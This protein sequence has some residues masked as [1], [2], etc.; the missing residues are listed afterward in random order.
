ML[1]KGEFSELIEDE[2]GWYIYKAL[3]VLNKPI[4]RIYLQRIYFAKRPPQIPESL[5]FPNEEEVQTRINLIQTALQQG[6]DFTDVAQ[7]YS[8]D[9]EA[10]FSGGGVSQLQAFGMSKTNLGWL[11]KSAIFAEFPCLQ[12]N[13]E[14]WQVNRPIGPINSCI[15]THFFLAEDMKTAALEVLHQN[16]MLMNRVEAE[17]RRKLNQEERMELFLAA[18]KESQVIHPWTEL[19]SNSVVAT[20]P[21]GAELTKSDIEARLPEEYAE[22]DFQVVLDQL[23][24]QDKLNAEIA[25]ENI[26]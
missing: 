22:A 25:R 4:K 9:G 7:E 14:E 26:F 11:S 8:S 1:N 6:R 3:Q 21:S 13:L 23:A 19:S 20:L 15:G 12:A 18:A 10:E 16:P 2:N 5:T 24:Y 17:T